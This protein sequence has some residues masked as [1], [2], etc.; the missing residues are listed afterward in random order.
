MV[1]GAFVVKDERDS[2]VLR[3]GHIK[4]FVLIPYAQK[5]GTRKEKVNGQAS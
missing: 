5:G 3:T 2:R 1:K 4:N